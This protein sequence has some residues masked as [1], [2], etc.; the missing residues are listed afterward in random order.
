LT[1]EKSE[2]L[3]DTLKDK[4]MVYYFNAKEGLKLMVESLYYGPEALPILTILLATDEKMREDFQRQ[5]LYE[6]LIDF[7]F[8]RNQNAEGKTLDNYVVYETLVLLE[9]ASMAEVVRSN[10]SE[11]KK[12]KDLFLVVINSI[13]IEEN[14]KLVSSLIQFVSNL[15]YGTGKFRKMLSTTDNAVF[16]KSM[17]DIL[18]SVTKTPE[19][20]S[21][22]NKLSKQDDAD[23]ALLH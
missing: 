20:R 7:L 21:G 12:I 18:V 10:L 6:K 3:L 8:N 15:C 5:H 16:I 17:K 11:K 4:D 2:Q 1:K 9:N 14:R 13:N 23:R 19:Q 22:K